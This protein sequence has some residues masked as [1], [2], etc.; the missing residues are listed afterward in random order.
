M[1]KAGNLSSN[2]SETLAGTKKQVR[3]IVDLSDKIFSEMRIDIGM[4]MEIISSI[5]NI[6]TALTAIVAVIIGGFAL[7]TWRNEFI[8]KKKIELAA[9]IKESITNMDAKNR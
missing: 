6:L 2:K 9:E 1:I 8:G 4:F 7:Y 5:S 3:L